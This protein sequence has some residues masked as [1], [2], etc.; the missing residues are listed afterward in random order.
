MPRRKTLKAR[1]LKRAGSRRQR[2]GV[3]FLATWFQSFWPPED[4]IS[5][6]VKNFKRIVDDLIEDTVVEIKRVLRSGH[7]TFLERKDLHHNFKTLIRLL[8]DKIE[9]I[10]QMIDKNPDD[11]DDL[12]YIRTDINNLLHTQRD[13]GSTRP[14][15][16]NH[17]THF[18]LVGLTEELGIPEREMRHRSGTKGRKF[19]V[20]A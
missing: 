12:L 15:H 16:G 11:R 9:E 13:Y 8:H 3:T 17:R 5:A 1:R 6:D 14:E 2:G 20:W 10:N 19:K 4:V 18:S 7:E